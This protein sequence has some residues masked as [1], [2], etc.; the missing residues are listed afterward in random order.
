MEPVGWEPETGTEPWVGTLVP[1]GMPGL[2]V[3]KSW[4]QPRPPKPNEEL[5]LRG[6]FKCVPA[7]YNLARQR[8]GETRN[9]GTLSALWSQKTYPKTLG[10]YFSF[11]DRE[12]P[13]TGE[14]RFSALID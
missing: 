5:W 3:P 13:V 14:D 8:K 1:W 10:L 12:E 11:G 2:V 7:I 9:C 4:E 6:S